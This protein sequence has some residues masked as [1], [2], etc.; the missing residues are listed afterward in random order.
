MVVINNATDEKE[1]LKTVDITKDNKH[2]SM[3]LNKYDDLIV[4]FSYEKDEKGYWFQES[5][6]VNK[7]DGE[8]YKAVDGTFASYSG[9]VFFDTHGA[10]LLLLNENGNYRFF[11]ME[12]F[13]FASK[14]IKCRFFDDSVENT[15]MK[16]L[17]NRLHNSKQQ[18]KDE[19]I[20]KPITLNKTLG[21]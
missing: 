7:E 9:D 10:N 8:L 21:K 11:F 19:V 15:S 3:S 4:S 2:I 17:F 13:C 5:F 20:D 18:V 6:E 1:G 16:Y 12:D 14:E